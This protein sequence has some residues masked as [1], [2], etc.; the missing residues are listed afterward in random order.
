MKPISRELHHVVKEYQEQTMSIDY[1]LDEVMKTAASSDPEV[2]EAIA[3]LQAQVKSMRYANR[4][5]I[6][7]L[8][9]HYPEK[10]GS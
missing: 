6:R 9:A 7:A 3:A 2:N 10:K 5:L 1:D 4:R 8:N